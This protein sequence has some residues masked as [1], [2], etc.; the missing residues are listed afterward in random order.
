MVQLKK[1]VYRNA[2]IKHTIAN[3]R[4]G[5]NLNIEILM[6]SDGKAA[7]IK[8]VV[9]EKKSIVNNSDNLNDAIESFNELE[10]ESQG[11][12]TKV[13]KNKPVIVAAK[14]NKDK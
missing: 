4:G 10:E 6:G 5:R 11:I 13:P 3:S 14:E 2:V 1:E 9:S 12:N 8:F 7:S